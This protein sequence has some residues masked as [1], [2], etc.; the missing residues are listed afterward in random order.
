MPPTVSFKNERGVRVDGV[1]P[2][3][4]NIILT[5]SQNIDEKFYNTGVTHKILSNVNMNAGIFSFA[6]NENENLLVGCK[7]GVCIFRF[8]CDKSKN[9]LIF[10]DDY[11]DFIQHPLRQ[12]ID[13]IEAP[14][15]GHIFATYTYGDEYIY[16][17]DSTVGNVSPVRII[18]NHSIFGISWSLSSGL[19]IYAYSLQAL[20]AM[21]TNS[22]TQSRLNLAYDN[23]QN[24]DILLDDILL[25]WISGYSCIYTHPKVIGENAETN[26]YSIY[27]N[28]NDPNSNAAFLQEPENLNKFFGNELFQYRIY[29]MVANRAGNLLAVCFLSSDGLKYKIHVFKMECKYKFKLLGLKGEVRLAENEFVIDFVFQE[30]DSSVESD[31]LIVLCNDY[32]LEIVQI[33][34]NQNN[35]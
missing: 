14:A 7:Q 3:S 24:D 5:Y 17:W 11:A 13:S 30:S 29:K 4:A 23:P 27:M 20:S 32:K 35:S 34:A 15:H 28:P 33:I 21:E 25:V 9:N 6:W 16:I 22:W 2:I 1:T 10:I 26:I 8:Q 19:Y 31:A 12:Q 18:N